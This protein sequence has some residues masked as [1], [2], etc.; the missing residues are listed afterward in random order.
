MRAALIP[1]VFEGG[2][3]RKF[4][5]VWSAWKVVWQAGKTRPFRYYRNR[6]LCHCTDII[7]IVSISVY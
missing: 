2:W 1:L 6:I 5:P 4:G 3:S 7:F